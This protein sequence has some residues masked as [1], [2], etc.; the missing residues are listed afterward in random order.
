MVSRLKNVRRGIFFRELFPRKAAFSSKEK[1]KKLLDDEINVDCLCHILFFM[2]RTMISRILLVA[3]HCLFMTFNITAIRAKER[4][5]H[6]ANSASFCYMHAKRNEW[7]Q[8]VT[9]KG[10]N[11]CGAEVWRKLDKQR[12]EKFRIYLKSLCRRRLVV[13]ILGFFGSWWK[14]SE[15]IRWED[16]IRDA[17]LNFDGFLKL[18]LSFVRW[19]IIHGRLSWLEESL[20]LCCSL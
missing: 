3:F 11:S 4:S 14:I 9:K 7:G 19:W 6:G 17:S 1:R 5:E 12:E 10:I 16:W 2:F 18:T 13:F 20:L 15:E 8:S